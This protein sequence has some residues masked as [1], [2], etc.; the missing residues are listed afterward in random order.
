[1]REESPV[2]VLLESA[3]AG[4]E[5]AWREIVSRY[6]PLVSTMCR[7]H[8]ITGTDAEDV[9]GSVWLRLV[10]K[11]PTIREPKA[12]PKWLMTVTTRECLALLR[13][14]GRHVPHEDVDDVV[15]A[16]ELSLLRGEREDAVREALSALSGRD[17]ELLALLFA[18][19]PVP[20][21]KISARLGMPIGAIG[22]TRQ[23]CLAR[24]RRVPSIAALL[25]DRHARTR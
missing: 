14:K 8:R 17:R 9:A 16:E 22:P 10:T 21:A 6:S 1:M 20:Y 12:L 25:G 15:A 4:A 5:P 7:R 13:D 3:T 2:G 19:P 24:V 23:R 11:L 18:D